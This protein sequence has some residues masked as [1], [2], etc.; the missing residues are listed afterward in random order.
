M[1]P[2]LSGV[3]PAQGVVE[4]LARPDPL[5]AGVPDGVPLQAGHGDDP[6]RLPL[7]VA[8]LDHALEGLE[9]VEAE[10]LE[11]APRGDQRL[12]P[13]PA[14][15]GPRASGSRQVTGRLEPAISGT[16]CAWPGRPSPGLGPAVREVLVDEDRD[17]PARRPEDVEHL[18]EEPPAGVELLELLVERVVAV[19]G[20]Q[21]HAVDRE[22]AGAQ[23][24]RIGDRRAE[25]DAV[26][27]R[28]GPAQVGRVGDLLD[29]QAGDLE[30]GP[31]QRPSRPSWTAKPSRN[32]PTM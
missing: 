24:Q 9:R 8:A 10:D 26:L 21:Q 25:P 11:V 12:L 7:A 32:R 4:Q 6:L 15:A 16:S 2:G 14:R 29:E 22:L 5:V 30:V 20:D 27:R 3:A 1:S 18:A 19:L 17:A 31:V 13:G 23:G 28:L